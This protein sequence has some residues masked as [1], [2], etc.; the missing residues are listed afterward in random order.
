M[1]YGTPV[2]LIEPPRGKAISCGNPPAAVGG[3]SYTHTFPV[4]GAPPFTF[5]IVSGKLPAGLVLNPSTGQITGT[6]DTAV[7]CRHIVHLDPDE[8][9]D[10]GQ[11]IKARWRS[12]FVRGSGDYE[13]R[14]VRVGNLDIWACGEGTLDIVVAGPDG[15]PSV[16]PPMLDPGGIPCQL[17][18][19]PGRMYMSKFDLSHV[20]NF[21]V[22][23]GTDG[24]DE[25]FE[26]RGFTGYTKADLYNR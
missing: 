13:S 11:P 7:V 1:T 25:W 4:F 15:K 18:D 24:I 10:Q 6:P 20:D 12:G 2:V 8:H 26:L 22:E 3:T 19:E 9:N 17:S 23:F 16:T 5:S 21:V 14:M